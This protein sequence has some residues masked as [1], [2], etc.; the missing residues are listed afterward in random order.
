MHG[1]VVAFDWRKGTGVIAL[2]DVN[3]RVPVQAAD[4]ALKRGFLLEGEEVSFDLAETA[5]GARAINVVLASAEKRWTGTVLMFESGCGY[6]RVEGRRDEIFAHHTNILGAEHQTLYPGERVEFEL[7]ET[8]STSTAGKIVKLDVR[9]MLERFAVCAD[10]D[11]HL[12]VLASLAR[13]ENWESSRPGETPRI[14]LR[15]Y[16]HDLF[17]QVEEEGKIAVATEAGGRPIVC[18]N[19]GLVTKHQEVLY[20][21][22]EECRDARAGQKWVFRAFCTA[23]DSRLFHFPELPAPATYFARGEGLVYDPWRPLTVDYEQ[24]LRRMASS[25]EC[26]VAP[27]RLSLE[28]AV[29]SALARVKRNYK[30]AVP[31][32]FNRKI[33]L[34]LPLCLQ[35]SF[36]AD[37][38]LVVA[39][40]KT[41]YEASMVLSLDAAYRHARLLARPDD[42]W[43]TP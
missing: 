38:A 14:V 41:G 30:T 18:F 8:G 22:F 34:L 35:T 9:G 1:T 39:L 23:A 16:V 20:G 26:K 37:V 19:T 31:V 40:N 5:A 12:A 2:R 15:H 33:Q 36:K 32:Y 10:L 25:A 6:I 24:V 28:E 21:Y 11:S 42:E 7:M 43:L 29:K 4:V 27:T 3:Q 17:A 13:P